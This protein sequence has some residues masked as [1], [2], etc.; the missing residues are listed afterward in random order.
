LSYSRLWFRKT[1]ANNEVLQFINNPVGDLLSLDRRQEPDHP[2][3][4]DSFGR[5]TNKVDAASTTDF[6]SIP[7]GVDYHRSAVLG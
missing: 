7:S 1:A 2:L 6:L 4:Y 5:V 3:K